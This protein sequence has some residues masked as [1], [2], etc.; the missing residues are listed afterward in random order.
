MSTQTTAQRQN[1]SAPAES[2]RVG[3]LDEDRALLTV[4]ANRLEGRGWQHLRLPSTS[5][6]S[7][8]LAHGLAAAIIDVG[9]LGERSWAWLSEL[10][11]RRGE[12]RVVVC[13][14]ESTPE[15]RIRA[16]RLGVD[17]WVGKP[18]HPEELVAR[19]EA[20]AWPDRR[21]RTRRLDAIVVGE[22]E[23]RPDRYQAFVEGRTLALTPR[24]Y[25]LIE[26]LALAGGE[27]QER[28]RIYAALW[29]REMARNARS[30]DVCV[31]KLRRKLEAASP[32]WRYI[33]TR[34]GVGYG[35][36]ARRKDA[37]DASALDDEESHRP[38]L[39]A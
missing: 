25:H 30:V 2:R 35:L 34:Y 13:A 9:V 4:L 15:Q 12:T 38:C 8:V 37:E 36:T 7:R 14:A 22:V 28:E 20:V 23:I 16:L 18:Y 21:R 33:T 31:H 6:P 17:D 19:V 1:A 10:C 11:E 39:A 32:G 24:E 27:I 3:I 29:G 26:M 5:T